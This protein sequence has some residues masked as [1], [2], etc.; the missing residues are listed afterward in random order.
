MASSDHDQISLL[1]TRVWMIE[2]ALDLKYYVYKFY[3]RGLL[4]IYKT[5]HIKFYKTLTSFLCFLRDALKSLTEVFELVVA[6][7]KSEGLTT[8]LFL[9]GGSELVSL[10]ILDWR[11]GD[12]LIGIYKGFWKFK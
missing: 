9:A 8:L 10:D 3:T 5:N 12:F 11:S 2:I 7:T 1:V 4:L 6:F